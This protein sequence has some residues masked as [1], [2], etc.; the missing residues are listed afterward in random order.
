MIDSPIIV[1]EWMDA[2]YKNQSTA[3]YGQLDCDGKWR[4]DQG[5]LNPKNGK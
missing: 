4:D 2:L 3:E 5:N 1:K